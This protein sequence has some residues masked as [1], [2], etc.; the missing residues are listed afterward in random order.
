VLHHGH[1]TIRTR[2]G[3]LGLALIHIGEAH[4]VVLVA[5]RIEGRA[6][7]GIHHAGFA[8][9]GF[10]IPQ[11][12]EIGMGIEGMGAAINDVVAH[13]HQI[14]APVEGVGL[15]HLDPIRRIRF[16]GHLQ[17][18]PRTHV[19]RTGQELEEALVIGQVV[20]DQA[21]LGRIAVVGTEQGE[22]LG[23]VRGA[24]VVAQGHLHQIPTQ[25]GNIRIHQ[26]GFH[27]HGLPRDGSSRVGRGSARQSRRRQSRRG[28]GHRA[29]GGG[30]G[31]RGAIGDHGLGMI[32][33]HPLVP[34]QVAGEEKDEEQN[35]A[36]IVHER[37]ILKGLRARGRV[38][39]GA[40]D[41]S[42]PGA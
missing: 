27:R 19:Q 23:L 42:G 13:I 38:R 3:Q 24:L 21:G 39:P 37:P 9:G 33:L 10:V 8:A 34:Q 16:Q 2:L 25:G 5:F 35:Q 30:A 18:V 41:G 14:G 15:H 7:I 28:S 11:Q 12:L 26:V 20:P 32:E 22:G 40:T 29:I 31:G 4:L 17:F 6:R 36:S 1:P